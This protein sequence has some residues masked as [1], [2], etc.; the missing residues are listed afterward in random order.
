MLK[1]VCTLQFIT[2]REFMTHL[3]QV[4][5]IQKKKKEKKGIKNV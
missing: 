5:I 2:A 3:S 4:N 1:Q